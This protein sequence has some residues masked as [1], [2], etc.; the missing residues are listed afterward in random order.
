[1]GGVEGQVATAPSSSKKSA[2]LEV[3]V[4][5]LRIAFKMRD[6]A[7]IAQQQQPKPSNPARMERKQRAKLKHKART[8]LANTIEVGAVIVSPPAALLCT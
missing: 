5:A 7:R 1:M 6:I 3:T 2:Q 8:A 4:G